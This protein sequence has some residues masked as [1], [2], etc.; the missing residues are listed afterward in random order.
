M[1]FR[2]VFIKDNIAI[3][4]FI[5]KLGKISNQTGQVECIECTEGTI[6]TRGGP[7]EEDIE[8]GTTCAPCPLGYLYGSVSGRCNA[9]PPGKDEENEVQ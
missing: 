8:G 2:Y 4:I 7:G 1:S 9:C 3:H 5:D 6:S